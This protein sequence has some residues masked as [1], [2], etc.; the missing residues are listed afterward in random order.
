MKLLFFLVLIILTHTLDGK[1][2]ECILLTHSHYDHVMGSAYLADRWSGVPV[3]S[4]EYTKYVFSRPTAK[5]MMYEM[6]VNAAHE[7]GYA[8]SAED[9]SDRLRADATVKD[10]DCAEVCG[11]KLRAMSFPGHTKCSIGFYCEDNKTLFSSET[12]GVYGE[13]MAMPIM[14]TSYIDGLASLERAKALGAEHIILPHYGMID[15]EKQCREYFLSADNEFKWVKDSVTG[16]YGRGM[17]TDEMAERIR[18]RYFIGHIGNVYPLKAFY[19]NTGYMIDVIIR[20][21]CS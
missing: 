13:G 19:M 1:K 8:P 18:E 4:G 7:M 10:G 3:I 17:D 14:L 9:M 20:E 6:D 16:W 21:F 11:L 5:K 12:L 15:G 2:P